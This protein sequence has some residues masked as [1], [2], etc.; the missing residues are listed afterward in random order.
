MV[1]I[2]IT[3]LTNLGAVPET[4]DELIIL[5]ESTNENKAI[6]VANLAGTMQDVNSYAATVTL[7]AGVAQTVTHGL[8]SYDVMV[9][10][11]DATTYENIIVTVDRTGTSTITLEADT[12][13]PNDVRVLIQKIIA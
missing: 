5:D 6:T 11:Y 1:G 8:T 2:D 7:A 9:Q 4:N 10:T 13:P 3:S 12:T